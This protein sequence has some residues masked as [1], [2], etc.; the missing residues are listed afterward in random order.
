MPSPCV[1]GRQFLDMY[2]NVRVPTAISLSCPTLHLKQDG[3]V[4]GIAGPAGLPPHMREGTARV[5][6]LSVE[7]PAGRSSNTFLLRAGSV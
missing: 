4:I 5:A 7:K 6:R 2:L 3:C 1:V